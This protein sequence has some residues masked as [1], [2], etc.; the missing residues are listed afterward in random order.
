[1]VTTM[2]VIRARGTLRR[3]FFASPESSMTLRNP[4]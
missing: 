2:V 4:V 3:G 1:M